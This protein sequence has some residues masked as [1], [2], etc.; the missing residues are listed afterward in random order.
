LVDLVESG[1]DG[2]GRRTYSAHPGGSPLNVAVGLA[3]L[4]HDTALQARLAADA[5]GRILR[6]HAAENGVDL[7]AAVEAAEPSTLAVV[8]LDAEGRAT[9]DFYIDGT[10]DWQWQPAELRELPADLTVLHTGSLAAWTPPGAEVIADVVRRTH[11]GGAVLVS[12]DPNVR[13]RL[14]GTPERGRAAVE[15]SVASSHLVK[16][17]D[18]DVRWLYPGRSLDDVAASW[19]SLGA[20]CIIITRGGDGASGYRAGRAPLHRPARPITLVDTVGAGD[21]FTAGLL[22]AIVDA[23]ADHP[24]RLAELADDILTGLIDEAILV[25]ALTCERPGADPPTRAEL[26]AAR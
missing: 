1:T 23:G 4:G 21:A 26:V 5:F 10:A 13:P 20:S 15:A 18:E 17:S 14:L 24:R 12:Y 6:T 16:A 19:L 22:G 3:R 2:G 9:Y 8:S 11:A 7:S 25:A